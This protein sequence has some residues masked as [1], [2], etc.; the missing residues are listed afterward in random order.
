MSF[1]MYRS[2]VAGIELRLFQM[3]G[4][5]AVYAITVLPLA[6]VFE[7]F[8]IAALSTRPTAVMPLSWP[9]VNSRWSW[10]VARSSH[11]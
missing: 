8:V 10:I 3:I 1:G 7:M 6:E 4:S 11:E 2:I 9:T 5:V